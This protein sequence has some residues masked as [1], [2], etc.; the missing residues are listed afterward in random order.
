MPNTVAQQMQDNAPTFGNVLKSVGEGVVASQKKLDASIVDTITKLNDTKITVV[1]DVVMALDDDGRPIVDADNLKTKDVSVLNYFMPTVHEWKHVAL[2]MDLTLSHMDEQYGMT[3]EESQFSG[4]EGGVGLFLGYVGWFQ[5][6]GSFESFSEDVNVQR[7]ADWARGQVRLDAQLS[8][9]RTTKFPV[10]AQV[11][12]GPQINLIPGPITEKKENNVLKGRSMDL[13]V[14]ILK[15][16]GSANPNLTPVVTAGGFM[17]AP[18]AADA[19]Y[20][21]P[22]VTNASGQTKY[23]VTRNFSSPSFAQP[24]KTKISV[25]LNDMTKTLDIVL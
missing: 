17:V 11:T 15:V 25:R 14:R 1:T 16:D 23:T 24:I 12:L 13:I 9:R 6:G 20:P 4:N 3:F 7:E 5:M 22:G 2:S 21:S 8:P 18:P 19:E 10:A